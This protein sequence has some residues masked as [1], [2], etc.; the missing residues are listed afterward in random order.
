MSKAE[1]ALN[2]F[3]AYNC[4]QSTL[5]AYAGDFG[6]DMETALSLAVGFGAGMGRVQETCGAVTGAI[7]VLGLSSR[8]KKEDGRPKINEVYAKVHRFIDEFSRTKGTVKCRELLNCDL[9]TEDGQKIFKEK[10]LR[11]NC[12]EY[13]RLCCEMLDKYLAEGS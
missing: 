1:A 11:E 3:Q 7:M 10:N 6:M 9:C 12:R 5:A 8:F 2:F 13:V 4:A